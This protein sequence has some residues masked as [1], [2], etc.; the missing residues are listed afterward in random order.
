MNLPENRIGNPQTAWLH[1]ATCALILFFGVS[2][3]LAQP[4]GTGTVTG[5][6]VSSISG[7]YLQGAEVTVGNAPPVLTG[8]D[9]SF[10]VRDV[11]PGAQAVRVY[12][13]GLD[14]STTTV[15]VSSF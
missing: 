1:V 3:L 11:S 5:R 13:T 2:V 15:N 8:R 10:V 14:L 12:Y 4:Q 7:A 6:V 9:G